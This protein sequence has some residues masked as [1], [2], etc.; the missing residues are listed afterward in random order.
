M[1][2]S[3]AT[4]L[5]APWPF[6][7]AL[8]EHGD[9][10]LRGGELELDGVYGSFAPPCQGYGQHKPKRCNGPSIAP[11]SRLFVDEE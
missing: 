4:W 2:Q 1:Q 6:W 11:E 8:D 7:V 3:G 9:P 5:A 10:I